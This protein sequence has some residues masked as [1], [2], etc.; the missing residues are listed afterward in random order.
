MSDIFEL[1]DGTEVGTGLLMPSPVVKSSLPAYESAGPLYTK[2][3]LAPVDRRGIFG[4]DWIVNQGRF[5]SCNGWAGSSALERARVLAGH[6]RVKLSGEY[7]Y[8]LINGGR[9]QGSMLDDGMNAVLK[10]GVAPLEF[11]PRGRI[12]RHQQTPE[13]H[14][15]AAKFRALECYTIESEIELASA[16][17]A[18]FICVV[19]VH[20]DN[21]F[22]RLDG[23]GVAGGGQGPGNHAV[24]VDSMKF[25]SNGEIMFDMANSWGL[26][27]GNSGR[28]FLT[29]VRHFRTTKQYHEFYAIRAVVENPDAD[30]P[31]EAK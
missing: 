8:S 4:D 3:Q 23:S 18:G 12:Y 19:A 21:G 2:D 17:Q 29:W 6:Q 31:P 26:T 30:N 11:V 7:L 25:A 9:D 16:I 20:A 28:A 1:P 14:N 22:M 5:G 15:A 13:S 24:L 27:Y 10:Y